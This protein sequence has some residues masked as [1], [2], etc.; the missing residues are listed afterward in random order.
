LTRPYQLFYKYYPPKEQIPQKY[1]KA[2][3]LLLKNYYDNKKY[4]DAAKIIE[5]LP[6]SQKNT[7]THL[8][9][10]KIYYN[11]GKYDKAVD[12]FEKVSLTND[13]KYLLCISY[14]RI[15]KE[16]K[17]KDLLINLLNLNG[18]LEKARSESAIKRIVI[19]I[20]NEKLKKEEEMK[21][22]AAEEV[23]R[24]MEEERLKEE[25]RKNEKLMSEQ[26]AGQETS[27]NIKEENTNLQSS[28]PK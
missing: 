18:Y 14:A 5:T 12:Y 15:N 3:T 19:E 17:A 6:E 22:V 23:K 21:N 27:K 1:L 25:K 24:K 13:D 7:E 9:T 16:N 11:I 10:A 2:F 28:S 26:K 8:M 20:E 4:E